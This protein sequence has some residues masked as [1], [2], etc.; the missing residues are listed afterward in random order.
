[1][2]E[3]LRHFL[4]HLLYPVVIE[5]S[6]ISAASDEIIARQTAGRVCYLFRSAL[7]SSATI[8]G[9]VFNTLL[10]NA[11]K[12]GSRR[13]WWLGWRRA[14]SVAEIPETKTTVRVTGSKVLRCKCAVGTEDPAGMSSGGQE[15][16]TC[17]KSIE[18]R[19]GEMIVE[20]GSDGTRTSIEARG[21]LRRDAIE[22]YT[23]CRCKDQ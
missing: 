16:E 23:T 22:L 20:V 19:G 3:R 9:L 13:D 2:H 21:V 18:D 1:M 11:W 8:T 12:I 15:V 7:T 17:G 10:T 5:P 6:C 4:S 14:E